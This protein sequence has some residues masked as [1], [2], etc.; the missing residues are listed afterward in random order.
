MTEQESAYLRLASDTTAQ[1]YRYQQVPSRQHAVFRCPSS[2]LH[3]G[4]PCLWNSN[5]GSMDN[6]KRALSISPTAACPVS[7]LPFSATFHSM[8]LNL[9]ALHYCGRHT[10]GSKEQRNE[11]VADVFDLSWRHGCLA[12]GTPNLCICSL[13]RFTFLPESIS[14]KQTLTS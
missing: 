2:A 12:C 8:P 6:G 4:Q 11:E 10:Q 7:A 1:A 9:R 14:N 13:I 5:S 3:E